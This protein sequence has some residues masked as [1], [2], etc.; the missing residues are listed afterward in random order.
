M[1]PH[2]PLFSYASRPEMLLGVVTAFGYC[3]G[4]RLG[5]CLAHYIMGSAFVSYKLAHNRAL[6]SYHTCR[7]AMLQSS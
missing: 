1:K 7:S 2:R 3:M 5:Q 4:G 6:L